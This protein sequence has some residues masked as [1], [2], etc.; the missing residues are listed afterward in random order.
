MANK[1]GISRLV[2]AR[3]QPGAR[4]PRSS[5][6][7]IQSRK[8]FV[9]PKPWVMPTF[10]TAENKQW[11]IEIDKRMHESPLRLLNN[12]GE[13]CKVFSQVLKN[14]ELK[15]KV[16]AGIGASEVWA[17]YGVT[18]D[19]CRE[20]M[21]KLMPATE[22]VEPAPTTPDKKQKAEEKTEQNAADKKEKDPE[23]VEKS[24][25][26][27]RPPRSMRRERSR[28]ELK[29][30][31]GFTM[32]ELLVCIA[33][34][35]MLMSLLFPAIVSVRGSARLM[36][37]EATL[38]GIGQAHAQ[39]NANDPNAEIMEAKA[40]FI[41]TLYGKGDVP[42]GWEVQVLPYLDNVALASLYNKEKFCLDESPNSDG[43]PSNL[44]V[45]RAASD[46]SR[47]AG[48]SQSVP[49]LSDVGVIISNGE[50]YPGLPNSPTDW[51]IL[52]NVGTAGRMFQDERGKWVPLIDGLIPNGKGS[53]RGV[54]IRD[55]TALDEKGNKV[56]V[57]SA[58]AK[59][60]N[61]RPKEK[62]IM[63][64]FAP[65]LYDYDRLY[66]LPGNTLT[67]ARVVD[68]HTPQSKYT[69]EGHGLV[70]EMNTILV[71]TEGGNTMK[72]NAAISQQFL[73]ILV[74]KGLER[75]VLKQ[76]DVQDNE[77]RP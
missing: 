67:T 2:A 16:L 7:E 74:Q 65:Q 19:K 5:Q 26:R 69:T 48:R 40:T 33:I 49:G 30:S 27:N 41:D 55:T 53:Q 9:E 43:G 35:G 50:I 56:A 36:Q 68:A 29:N 61:E 77:L 63:F 10:V 54:V 57:T 59:V 42:L 46:R 6:T 66:G 22:E 13:I 45:T 15:E 60:N 51:R 47:M 62:V 8:K 32:P 11:L 52:A 31:S 76:Q 58:Q 23:K 25:R 1:D 64:G 72:L 70:K 20:F 71:M 3:H 38:R 12:R 28:K 24:T 21:A 75:D 34:I 37:N 4:A 73:N 44:Q 39:H 17:S 14:E 18:P